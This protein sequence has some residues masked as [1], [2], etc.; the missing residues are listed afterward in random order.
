MVD[1]VTAANVASGAN[2]ANAASSSNTSPFGNIV[3]RDGLGNFSATMITANLNGNAS[4]ATT[5]VSAGSFTGSLSGDVTGTQGNTVVSY[6]DQQ[7][8]ANVAAA[9]I[10]ANA[11]TSTNGAKELVLR[12]GSGNFAAGTITASLIG[13]VTGNLY[14]NATW[15]LRQI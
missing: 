11:A 2:A 5:A 15:R 9:T 4:S 3:K 8:A 10:I 7:P 1:N 12:D 6:V 13:T 14:G